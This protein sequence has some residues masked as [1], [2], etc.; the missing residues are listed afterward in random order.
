MALLD[1]NPRR[2]CAAV[3]QHN[4]STDLILSLVDSSPTTR[5]WKHGRRRCGEVATQ[6]RKKPINSVNVSSGN[7]DRRSRPCLN[8]GSRPRPPGTELRA[9][10]TSE[11]VASRLNRG[12]K[13]VENS[14]IVALDRSMEYGVAFEPCYFLSSAP[15]R[16]RYI[17]LQFRISC[18]PGR[19][20]L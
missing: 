18:C 12:N 9:T 11:K 15:R 5:T 19:Q 13:Q 8:I 17:F 10:F 1:Q 14:C 2:V 16:R 4:G 6:R 3:D 7:G 20:E